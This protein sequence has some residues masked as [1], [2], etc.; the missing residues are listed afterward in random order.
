MALFVF[1]LD[2]FQAVV[3]MFELMLVRAL[4]DIVLKELG[5]LHILRAELAICDELALF[6]QVEVV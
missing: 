2:D 5:N 6:G 4:L 3:A 1:Y